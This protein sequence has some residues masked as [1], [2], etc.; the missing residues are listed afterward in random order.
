M[1]KEQRAGGGGGAGVSPAP[2]M[3]VVVITPDRFETVRKTVRHLRAQ[4][5]CDRIELV[6]AAPAVSS[7]ALDESALRDFSACKVIEVGPMTSTARARAAGV[8]EAR[9]PIVAIVEDH[10][11]AAETRHA[12]RHAARRLRHARLRRRGRTRR[13]RARRGARD[14]EALRHGVSPAPL[15][16]TRAPPAR[17]RPE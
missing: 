13:L 17:R 15:R 12:A 14:G 9:A 16:Q 8:R 7:L 10:A 6:I 3:S 11:V 2:A 4:T 5:V 1:K